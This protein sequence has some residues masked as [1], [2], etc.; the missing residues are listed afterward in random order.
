[1]NQ[2]TSNQPLDADDLNP[3]PMRQLEIWI[4][5]ARDAGQIE[6]TAMTLATAD[7][8][9]LP[10]ARIVLFKGL[11]EGAPSFYTNYGSAKARM[12]AE[13]PHAALVF[14][15]DRLERQV[16]LEGRVEKLPRAAGEGYFAQRPRDSQ[17]SAAVSRQSRP[18]ASREEI[19]ARMEAAAAQYGDSPIP[20][21]ENWGGYR[22][23]PVRVEFWQGRQ[24]RA[25]DRLLYE[26]ATSGWRI[27]RLEP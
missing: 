8:D 4:D 12:L 25:H 22:L 19:D 27:V 2:Y 14:W 9:G 21:P 5:A 6:P 18:V 1:M 10:A 13:N 11:Y 17:L 3:D 15:W 24:A 26:K 20:C 7:A 16:R 23:L